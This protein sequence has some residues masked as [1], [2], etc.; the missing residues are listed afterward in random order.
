MTDRSSDCSPRF[1]AMRDLAVTAAREEGDWLVAQFGEKIVT[2]PKGDDSLVT[3]LDVRSERMIVERIRLQYPEHTIIGEESSPHQAA[4]AC[5][6]AVDPIDGTRNFASGIP[7]WAVSIAALE[8]GRPVAAA[9]YLPVTGE[10]Y[11]AVEGLGARLNGRTLRVSTTERLSDAVVMT[12]LLPKGHPEGLPGATLGGLITVSRRTRMLGSV[13]CGMCYVA[14]GRFDLYYRPNVSVW[15]VAAGVLLVEEA[16]G[17]VRSFDGHP[18][19]ADSDSVLA[20]NAALVEHFLAEKRRL[21]R[22]G[23]GYRG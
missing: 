13:C 8:A 7:L 10:M 3:E 11:E 6:W 18:W 1:E 16:G 19:Q 20:A 14:A 15:D 17:A 5:S 23:A 9:A 21:E 2:T 22:E 12:D 4:G